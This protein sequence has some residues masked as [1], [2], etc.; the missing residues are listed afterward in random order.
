MQ[1]RF[2][3]IFDII[4]PVMVGPSSSHTA[5]AVRIGNV[6]R[7]ILNDELDRVLFYLYG[8][9]AD[10]YKGHGTDVALGGGILGMATDDP[11]IPTSLLLAK[12]NGI[13]MTFI[14][15]ADD[16]EHPNTV[17]IIMYAKSGR[18]VRVRAVSIGGG[19][20]SI[21][22]INDIVVSMDGAVPNLLILHKDTP[23]MIA[24]VAS[25]LSDLD[26][27]IATMKVDRVAKGGAA[28]MIIELDQDGLSTSVDRIKKLD[29]V[30]EIIYI[31]KQ[32]GGSRHD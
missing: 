9:F 21:I 19:S 15:L 29:G 23:G 13:D 31:P 17:E 22:G 7:I 26:I 24:K 27:N 1:K 3:S 20:I 16:V 2:K 25:I 28:S 11:A 10:T 8:S 4:G 32:T 18:K 30:A 14:P 12:E 6:A 5:G